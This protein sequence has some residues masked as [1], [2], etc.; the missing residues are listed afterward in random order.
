MRSLL[1]LKINLDASPQEVFGAWLNSKGHS[2]FTGAKAE[3]DPKIG[4]KFT[5]WDGYISGRTLK[6]EKGKKSD[7]WRIVQSWRTTEFL[8]D[9]PDSK[10]EVLFEKKGD[11]TKL[12]LIHTKIPE[13]QED[14]YK[15]GWKDYYFKPMKEY[16]KRK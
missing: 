14:M 16:F 9:T 4:G 3:I 15:E 11:G 6:I 8:K 1:I 13:G 7:K 5:A 10:I 2:D 12:T